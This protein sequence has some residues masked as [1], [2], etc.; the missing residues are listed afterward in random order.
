MYGII[1]CTKSILLLCIV[2]PGENL[3]QLT[4]IGDSIQAGRLSFYFLALEVRPAPRLQGL[5]ICAGFPPDGEMKQLAAASSLCAFC[6]LVYHRQ[7]RD[8]GGNRHAKKN[9]TF[10][11]K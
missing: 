4:Q 8:P 11:S 3:D 6:L 9:I 10:K 7:W 2:D 5:L 1:V